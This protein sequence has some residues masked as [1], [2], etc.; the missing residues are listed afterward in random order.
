MIFRFE[1]TIF[2]ASLVHYLF[3][4]FNNV[5]KKLPV[6][7]RPGDPFCNAA[8][9]DPYPTVGI[10][11]RVR[12]RKLLTKPKKQPRRL[13]DEEPVLIDLEDDPREEMESVLVNGV[14]MTRE[15][16]LREEKNLLK[17]SGKDMDSY[18]KRFCGKEVPEQYYIKIPV[19][20]APK[21]D[22]TVKVEALGI[23]SRTYKF[24][25]E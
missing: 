6:R 14:R 23:V 12:R 11:L 25:G 9:G 2:K 8:M 22:K 1:W 3:Q 24:N 4:V 18:M 16:I 5:K 20:Y 21:I 7:F 15:D 10:L 13:D 17:K 19:D